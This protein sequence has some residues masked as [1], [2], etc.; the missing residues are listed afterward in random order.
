MS[1]SAA[2]R[3]GTPTF[4]M[5]ITTYT[6]EG[7]RAAVNQHERGSHIYECCALS[8]PPLTGETSRL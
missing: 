1:A 8:A 7:L 5:S 4:L 3:G 2:T 6:H